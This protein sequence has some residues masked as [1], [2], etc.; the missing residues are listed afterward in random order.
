MTELIVGMISGTSADGVDAALVAFDSASSVKVIETEYTPYSDS[1]RQRINELAHNPQRIQQC[2]DTPLDNELAELY[3]NASLSLITKAGLSPD[4]IACVAS[5][6]QTVRHEPNAVP[7]FSLQL[8]APQLIAN[9]T[10]LTVIGNFRQADLAANGQGAPLMPA[11][12]AAIF[13]N[14]GSTHPQYVLNLGGIANVTQLSNP[15]IGWDTGPA[16]TLMDQWIL[17]CLDQ[18][19]DHSGDW[20]AG[21]Q[22]IDDLLEHWLSD[23]YFSAPAPKSTGPD[24][25]NLKWMGDV[26]AYSPQDVQATLMALSVQSIANEISKLDQ[27]NGTIYVCGG[28][29]HNTQLIHKL[30]NA[31]PNHQIDTTDTLGIP[32][33]W[34][35]AAGF[36]WLGYCYLHGHESNLPGVTGAK[37]S[38]VLGER[39]DPR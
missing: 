1:I 27:P 33:D 14:Q 11:F 19:Y 18:R 25:F 17:K 22:L 8:G 26:S 24:Y 34:V 20:A 35:E 29:A 30:R 23:P 5:H 39:F 2:A 6:G 32:V 28:G 9:H 10:R 16:S 37:K 21:G 38:L 31:L 36:A 4:N 3:A 12:H 13:E 7:P 15:V